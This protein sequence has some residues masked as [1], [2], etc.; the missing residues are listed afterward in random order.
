MSVVVEPTLMAESLIDVLASAGLA[1]V[2]RANQRIDPRG[3]V[4]K[5]VVFA[6]SVVSLFFLVRALGWLLNSDW[7][8]R[9][10]TT[11]AGA[12]PLAGLLVVE[13]L[14]RR[15]SPPFA[16]ASL[17]LGAIAVAVMTALNWR[18]T[19]LNQTLLF[20]SRR[21]RLL[22][23]GMASRHAGQTQPDVV[24]KSNHSTSSDRPAVSFWRC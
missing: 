21:R 7:L 1:I 12:T 20:C 15:H 22:S 14:L 5:R 3:P 10:A 2:A 24:G 16:K 17:S 4:T 13:G 18:W 9:F 11:L 19:T 8:S 6:L 23:S